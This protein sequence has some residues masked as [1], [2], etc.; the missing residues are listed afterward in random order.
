MVKPYLL[1]LIANV[2]SEGP[3]EQSRQGL[4]AH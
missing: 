2:I 3:G 1:E 4:A